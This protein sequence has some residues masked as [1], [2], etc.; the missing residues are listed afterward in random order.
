MSDRGPKD[1]PVRIVTALLYGGVVLGV[2]LL[3]RTTGWAILISLAAAVALA[4]FYSLTREAHRLPNEVFGVVAAAAM[5]IGAAF[6]G[7]LG[8]GAVF[9]IL[10]VASLLWHLAFRQVRLADTA[11][12]VFGVIYVGYTLAH[13]VLLRALDS[14]TIF[15]LATLASVW[16]NDIA[17]YLVGST[18]GRFKLAPRVS[19]NK[20]W[21]GFFAGIVASVAVWAVVWV[22]T[23]TGISLPWHLAIGAA[24]GLAG[25]TGDLVESRIK[26]EIGVKDSGRSL[27]GHGGFLDRLDALM[28]VSVA[29]YYLLVW[30]GA[31]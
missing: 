13:L 14:G 15:V 31:R 5:P 11:L 23:D 21:E 27:P 10:V 29:A 19:P 7:T 3:G 24:L 1:L 30:A 6:Y 25:V 22:I 28:L 20:T 2:L 4:E 18:I 17:A 16:L 26:R 12:T 9:T 8:L